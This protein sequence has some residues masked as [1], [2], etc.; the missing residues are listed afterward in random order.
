MAYLLKNGQVYLEHQLVT[1]DIRI[2]NGKI[3]ALGTDLTPLADETVFDCTAKLVTPGL[4]DPHVHLR[5][6]GQTDK[7]TIATG[8]AAAARGGFTTIG[9]MPNVIPVPDDAT[10]VAD[11][12]QRNTENGLVHILQFSSITKNREAGDLVDF[13]A[14]KQAGAFAVSNDG[15]GVQDAA[16][17]L[18]AL[19]GAAEAGLTLAAH[20]EEDSLKFGGV[21]NA[22]PKADELGVPGII[23]AV[24]TS[25]LARDIALSEATG[26]HYHMCH[27]ST[28]ASVRMI[29]QAK[30]AGIPVTAEVTPHHLLLSDEMIPGNDAN[31]KMNPPLRSEADRQALIE[32]LC[33]GTI[34]CIA[35]DHAPHTALEKAKGLCGSPFGITGSETA[36]DTLYT[37][38]VQ[39]A[40]PRFT[41]TQLLNWM[42]AAPARCFNIDAGTLLPGAAADIAVFDLKMPT[43]IKADEFASKGHNS[44]FVGQTV[45]GQTIATFVSGKLVYRKDDAQK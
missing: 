16:T 42:T 36:F 11:M 37:T 13:Q 3:A 38:F 17:M 14:V 23:N 5:D 27:V 10:K 1:C 44:P 32:G 19:A 18:K 30:A 6:P 8:S 28:A 43:T 31:Y 9:A 45:Y 41:L 24:E 29:R 2:Q 33:D 22:G 20:V 25:Q 35:T 7:E 39:G 15:S 26:A 34:D 4:V 21:I 12:V 40:Q